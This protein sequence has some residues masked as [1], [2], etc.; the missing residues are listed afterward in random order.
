M[1]LDSKFLIFATAQRVTGKQ[2]MGKDI[3]PKAFFELAC[4]T[5]RDI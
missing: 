1:V 3:G 4:S 2:A 5:I